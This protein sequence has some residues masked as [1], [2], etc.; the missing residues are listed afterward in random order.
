ML[1]TY[2]RKLAQYFS[3]TKDR[4]NRNALCDI[5]EHEELLTTECK[6]AVLALN[7]WST[8]DVESYDFERRQYGIELANMVLLKQEVSELAYTILAYNFL[9]T[10]KFVS[11]FLL[12]FSGLYSDYYMVKYK[13][14]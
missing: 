1:L 10:L 3:N 5:F 2:F 11:R 4:V 12:K 6:E 8:N 7:S 9:F 13:N 14:A